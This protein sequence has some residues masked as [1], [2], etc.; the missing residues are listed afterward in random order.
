MT[1][2]DT[3]EDWNAAFEWAEISYG[4][5]LLMQGFAKVEDDLRLLIM[6]RNL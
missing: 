6:I 1:L 4:L 2:F 3:A 5:S